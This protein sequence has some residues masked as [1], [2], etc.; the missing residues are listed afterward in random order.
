MRAYN[1][2]KEANISGALSDVFALTLD[3]QVGRAA[4][5][6]KIFSDAKSCITYLYSILLGDKGFL[7][8]RTDKPVR[9]SEVII[10]NHLSFVSVKDLSSQI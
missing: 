6:I 8:F 5:A 9:A 7:I 2:L 4:D 10:Q 3:N 1:T